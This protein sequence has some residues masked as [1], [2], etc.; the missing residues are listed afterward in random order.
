MFARL[1]GATG[2]KTITPPFP[3]GEVSESPILLVAIIYAKILFPFT[4]LNGILVKLDKGTKHEASLTIEALW[5]LQFTKSC[6]KAPDE[7]YK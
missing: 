1:I 6:M 3:E 5:P 2:T 7:D 4:K